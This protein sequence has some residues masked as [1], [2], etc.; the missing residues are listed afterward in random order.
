[1]ELQFTLLPHRNWS[2]TYLSDYSP[3]SHSAQ[4]F[5]SFRHLL[6]KP[7]EISFFSI[8]YFQHSADLPPPVL[9]QCYCQ[10]KWQDLDLSSLNWSLKEVELST[11]SSAYSCIRLKKIVFSLDSSAAHSTLP[12]M[13]CMSILFHGS[14]RE[15]VGVR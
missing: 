12:S 4:L 15:I 2:I 10:Y 5:S 1:M 9:S 14:F 3:V 8:I 7:S 6:A 11:I 13:R